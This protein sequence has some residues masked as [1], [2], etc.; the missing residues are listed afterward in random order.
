MVRSKRKQN[1][2]VNFLGNVWGYTGKYGLDL[3]GYRI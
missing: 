1:T 3:A 2:N